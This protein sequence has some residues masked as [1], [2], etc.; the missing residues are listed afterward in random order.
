MHPSASVRFLND[1][2]SSSMDGE[3]EHKLTCF[4]IKVAIFIMRA[5]LVSIM[6]SVEIQAYLI[7]SKSQV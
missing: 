2:Q 3:R 5:S 1:H 4:L 6:L 7:G